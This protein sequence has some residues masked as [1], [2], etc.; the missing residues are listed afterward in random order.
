M[1]RAALMSAPASLTL[2]D[3]ARTI[4]EIV[5]SSVVL[6]APFAPTIA[7]SVPWRTRALTPCST[8]LRP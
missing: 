1:G 7:Q 4:R 6:P 2:P 8:S 3:R 5:S